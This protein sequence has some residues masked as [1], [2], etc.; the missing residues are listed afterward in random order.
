M[1]KLKN[2][3][4][5]TELKKYT[6]MHKPRFEAHKAREDMDMPAAVIARFH[7]EQG[8]RITQFVAEF[9]STLRD[10]AR[11]AR[12]C[13]QVLAEAYDWDFLDLTGD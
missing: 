8:R 12:I 11:D 2:E 6:K 4:L 1:Y 7:D 3:E 13:G 5:E 9:R 10:N